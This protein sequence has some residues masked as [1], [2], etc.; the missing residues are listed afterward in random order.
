MK[1]LIVCIL[2]TGCAYHSVVRLGSIPLEA[3]H[4][5]DVFETVTINGEETQ[6]LRS[7]GVGFSIKDGYI[8]ATTHAVFHEGLHKPTFFIDEL[9]IEFIGWKRDVALFKHPEPK[10]YFTL[11]DVAPVGTETVL[12]GNSML[13]GVNIKTGMVSMLGVGGYEIPEKCFTHTTP[14]VKGD[15]GSPILARRGNGYEVIGMANAGILAAQGYNFGI[16]VSYIKEAI[17]EILE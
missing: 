1:V 13:R 15:S 11:G 2:L 9:E 4:V 6:I 7:K 3:V 17:K 5:I 12:I 10:G 8:L 16:C 14:M